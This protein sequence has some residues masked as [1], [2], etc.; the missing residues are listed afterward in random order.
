[1]AYATSRRRA[2][3]VRGVV[4]LAGSGSG[5]VCEGCGQP[6]SRYNPESRCRACVSSA[7]GKSRTS[8]TNARTLGPQDNMQIGPRLARIRRD[9][10]L[11]QE[12]LAES[13]GLSV[14]TV[15]K[16]EQRA[17]IWARLE[18]LS[19]LARALSIPIGELVQSPS[20][21]SGSTSIVVSPPPTSREFAGRKRPPDYLPADV[22]ARPDF[23]EACASRDLGAIFRIA[24]ECCG[25]SFTVSHLARRC[26][27]TSSQVQDYMTRGRLAQKARIFERVADGLHVPGDMLGI[28]RRPWEAEG[29]ERHQPPVSATGPLTD[30]AR[31]AAGGH[32]WKPS[33]SPEDAESRDVVNASDK[34]AEQVSKLVTWTEVTNVGSGTLTYLHEATLRLAHDCLSVPPL[35]SHQR[36]AVLTRRVFELLQAGRQRIGQTRD[37]YVTAGKLCAVLSWVVSDLGQLAS[38]ETHSRSGW[39]LADQADHDGLRALLLCT[40]S[41]NAFWAKRYD[42]A[43]RYARRGYEYKPSG[44]SRVLLACQE[45]DAHQAL[46]RVDDAQEALDR[47]QRAQDSLRGADD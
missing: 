15:R 36:A 31:S 37:L 11:T 29:A 32:T 39:T 19:A 10:G 24:T 30:V 9:R 27:M 38:A 14:N 5:R 44:T 46:G 45:A 2:S 22:L 41:K 17:K 25:V 13:A 26:E 33:S 1:M 16:L 3:P 6:L 34:L 47:A 23:A 4:S 21:Q 40:Q 35:Q 18:T 20:G 42:D 43:A 7:G 12:Q 8:R 28:G